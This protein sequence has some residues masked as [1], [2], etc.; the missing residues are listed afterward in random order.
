MTEKIEFSDGGRHGLNTGSIT[1]I[2]IDRVEPLEIPVQQPVNLLS[3][4]RFIS[5]I[6]RG[7][8]TE[9]IGEGAERG[10]DALYVP[11]AE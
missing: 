8:Q 9:S 1:N 4:R 3:T 6:D 10:Q 11:P 2:G 5:E 7:V